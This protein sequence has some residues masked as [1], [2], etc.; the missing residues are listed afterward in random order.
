MWESQFPWFKLLV[1]VVLCLT[2]PMVLM[3]L[4]ASES[5]SPQGTG[6]LGFLMFIV[7]GIPICFLTP[8]AFVISC[9]GLA[10]PRWQLRALI[11]IVSIASLFIGVLAGGGISNHILK[12]TLTRLAERSKPLITAINSYEHK[13]GQPPDTLEALVPEFIPKIPTTGIGATPDY[14]YRPL[15]NSSS[16]GDNK[17]VLQ[18]H[19]EPLGFTTF[20][21]LPLQDYSVL[22]Y[23][24]IVWKIG[25]W[26]YWN[27]G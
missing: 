2:I 17:W 16:Y 5:A 3:Y 19:P 21:Y 14:Q 6:S 20:I 25:D 7:L 23:G 27:Q 11:C 12:N 18:V 13:F 24:N 22:G 1:P 10:Y 9:I 8:I 15:T 26:A 4:A